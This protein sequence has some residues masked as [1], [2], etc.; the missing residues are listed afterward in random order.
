M[1]EVENRGRGRERR[2]E[3]RLVEGKEEKVWRTRAY[4]GNNRNNLLTPNL[5]LP[6]LTLSS[7]PLPSTIRSTARATLSGNIPPVRQVGVGHADRIVS[8]RFSEDFLFGLGFAHF[9]G[10]SWSCEGAVIVTE[11]RR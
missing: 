4:L 5:P 10:E 3:K 2:G 6:T 1:L 11:P 9:G 8:A 7:L